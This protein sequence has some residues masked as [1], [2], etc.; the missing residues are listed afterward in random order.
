MFIFRQLFWIECGKKAGIEVGST[1]GTERKNLISQNIYW[2]VGLTIDYPAKRL[3][4]I[5]S[6][7]RLVESVALDGSD[8]KF[9]FQFKAGK[10]LYKQNISIGIGV[11]SFCSTSY[12]SFMLPTNFSEFH[13]TFIKKSSS[14]FLY[15]SLMLPQIS[16]TM[17]L[18]KFLSHVSRIYHK[19]SLTLFHVELK[20]PSYMFRICTSEIF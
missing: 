3:Y 13:L 6:K 10:Y 2:P 4:W 1:D 5:D 16:H 8:R 11:F 20:F 14:H 19:Y 12:S 7:L 15:V 18:R 9:I 17:F